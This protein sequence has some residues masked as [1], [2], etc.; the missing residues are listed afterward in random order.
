MMGTWVGFVFVFVFLHFLVGV[1]KFSQL[2]KKKTE[3]LDQC[4][5]KTLHKVTGGGSETGGKRLIGHFMYSKKPGAGEAMAPTPVLLPG[6]FHGLR[7]LGGCSPR[8]REDSDTTERL[9]FLFSLSCIGE[10]NGSP[11]QCSYLENPRD[12]G[13]WWAAVYG[14]AYSWTQLKRLSSSSSSSEKPG[15]EDTHAHS[16]FNPFHLEV[17]GSGKSPQT[18]TCDCH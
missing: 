5:R 16:D 10:G 2:K 6:K 4:N 13:A 18:I 3:V 17:G 14:V 1:R 9:H 15:E 8:G 7:S 12:G 11:L